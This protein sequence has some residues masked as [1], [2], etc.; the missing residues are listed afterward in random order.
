MCLMAQ[1]F[2]HGRLIRSRS[3]ADCFR[4]FT[5]NHWLG[6]T[7]FVAVLLLTGAQ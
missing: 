6:L 1:V 7:W 3:R 4:A 5:Q 2:W